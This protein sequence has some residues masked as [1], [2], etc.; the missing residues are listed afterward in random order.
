[1]V[2]ASPF[3][4]CARTLVHHHHLFRSSLLLWI[5]KLRLICFN[6]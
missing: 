1:V 5:H 6:L 2:G 4:V 3:V